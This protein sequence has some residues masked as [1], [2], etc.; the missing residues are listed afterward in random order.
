MIVI[1]SF[2]RSH[3][4]L[5]AF[6]LSRFLSSL[7]LI[8][9]FYR[10]DEIYVLNSL[11]EI[12][13]HVLVGINSHCLMLSLMLTSNLLRCPMTQKHRLDRVDV[14][15]SINCKKIGRK[16]V[17]IGIKPGDKTHYLGPV[18]F[19]SPI[20]KGP[21][22]QDFR[23]ELLSMGQLKEPKWAFGNFTKISSVN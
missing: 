2:P 8:D 4:R 17:S 6:F 14:S 21:I 12:E 11:W 5:S 23:I 9:P 7:V 18:W 16:V 15:S 10:I 1:A 20:R 19:Q 22:E 3:E 13:S